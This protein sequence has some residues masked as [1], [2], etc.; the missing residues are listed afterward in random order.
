MIEYLML[1]WMQLVDSLGCCFQCII[2]QTKTL[3]SGTGGFWQ[4][5]QSCGFS[6]GR[7]SLP[8]EL[9]AVFIVVVVLCASLRWMCFKYAL[10]KLCRWC[11]FLYQDN[12]WGAGCSFAVEEVFE[13]Q[14]QQLPHQGL[15]PAQQIGRKHFLPSS[16]QCYVSS[17][18]TIWAAD[19]S[20]DA[21]RTGPPGTF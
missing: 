12:C 14:L 18:D 21:G 4:K 3:F 13:S 20:W 8:S 7:S 9:P 10:C 19:Q 6:A 16:S 5:S 2:S 17:S 11:H 15:S 1:S